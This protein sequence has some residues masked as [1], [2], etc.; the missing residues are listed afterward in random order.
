MN[1]TTREILIT[2]ENM[3]FYGE[4]NPQLSTELPFTVE[5]FAANKTNI[6][7]FHTAGVTRESSGSAGKSQTRNKAALEREVSTDCR[8]TS[9]TAKIMEKKIEGFENTFDFRRGNYSYVELIDWATAI[10]NDTR[11]YSADFAKYGLTEAFFMNLSNNV[12][13]LRQAT[14]EQSD[15]KRTSVG[16]TADT[17]SIIEDTLDVRAA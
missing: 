17:E 16:A 3:D 14:Q 4:A 7:R 9:K 1:D 11:K 6:Q 12:D 2:A 15:A 13:A 5:L 10:I 8:R